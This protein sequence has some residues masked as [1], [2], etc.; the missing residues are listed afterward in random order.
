MTFLRIEWRR[1][2]SP[3]GRDRSRR[4]G[5]RRSGWTSEINTVRPYVI[6]ETGD[7]AGSPESWRFT[8]F[9]T[10]HR[11]KQIRNRRSLRLCL[12]RLQPVVVN[13]LYNNCISRSCRDRPV[14]GKGNPTNRQ[15]Q[16][17]LGALKPEFAFADSTTRGP[18]SRPATHSQLEEPVFGRRIEAISTRIN[19]WLGVEA[20]VSGIHRWFPDMTSR[21]ATLR[22]WVP[23]PYTG[24]SCWLQPAAWQTKILFYCHSPIRALMRRFMIGSCIPVRMTMVPGVLSKNM[25]NTLIQ[26]H[27]QLLYNWT[28]NVTRYH[29]QNRSS[30]PICF[31]LMN[32]RRLTVLSLAQCHVCQYW[33]KSLPQPGFPFSENSAGIKK[34]SGGQF[35][36]VLRSRE[37]L[38]SPL[39]LS[40]TGC[41]F[42]RDSPVVDKSFT[43]ISRSQVGGARLGMEH[44]YFRDFAAMTCQRLCISSF[45][46]W[47]GAAINRSIQGLID[48]VDIR[49]VLEQLKAT[50]QLPQ[51]VATAW[52]DGATWIVPSPTISYCINRTKL[53]EK[54]LPLCH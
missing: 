7:P 39:E 19:G 43:E 42:S 50:L 14:S 10:G 48:H 40:S 11:P 31:S 45:Q 54:S 44:K 25:N 2:W 36:S 9:G 34:P 28:N 35:T 37:A 22:S 18:V 20:L 51:S 16:E 13:M 23:T 17:K 26:L 33:H 21:L 15:L 6:P 3:E 52:Y 27:N 47:T 24:R 8:P 1:D 49:S 32:C 4:V 53:Y 12:G 30:W 46:D 38:H 5:A 41:L 29:I